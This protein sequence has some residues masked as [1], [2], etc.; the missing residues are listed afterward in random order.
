MVVRIGVIGTGMIGQDHIRRISEVLSGCVVVAVTDVDSGKAQAV[1]ALRPGVKVHASGEA[2]VADPEVDAVVVTSWGPT[3]RQYVLAAIAGGKPV[4]CEKP[5][6]ESTQDCLDMLA[7]EVAAGRKWVQVGYMRR[8]DAAYRALKAVVDAGDIGVPLMVHCV[9]RN[10][11][12][13]GHYRKEMM[14][15]DTA[16]HEI[17]AMRWLLGEEIVAVQVLVPRKNAHGGTLQDPLILLLTMES[18]AIVDVEVSV[19][20]RYGYDIRGEVVG[21]SGTASLGEA[22]PVTV[23]RAGRFSGH[24]PADWR[25]RF[26]RAYDTEI[27]EWVD[28][29]AAGRP[30][31]GPTVWDGYVAA[32]VSEAGLEALHSG[33]RAEVKLIDKPALYT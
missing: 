11:S 32:V 13:P 7:A 21:E 1:G 2:V 30:A 28:G 3:H 4:F 22:S 23:R 17:D 5:L 9:H 24:I 29:V 8:Y 14:I 16:V 18:G 19:N 12:V 6:A 33:V 20:I 27:Q 31:A 26:V 10:P 15:T 25:E